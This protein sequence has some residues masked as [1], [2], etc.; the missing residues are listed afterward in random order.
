MRKI[1]DEPYFTSSGRNP[2]RI[3]FILGQLQELWKMFPD[4]RFGQLIV[5]IENLDTNS[6]PHCEGDNL[7]RMEDDYFLDLVEVFKTEHGK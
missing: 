2:E 1:N 5:N 4:M 6:S 3:E 7:F